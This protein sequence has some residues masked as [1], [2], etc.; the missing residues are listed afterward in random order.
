MIRRP[1]RSTLSSS[2]AASDVYKRQYQRRVR[3]QDTQMPLA[4]P[5][6]EHWGE[7]PARQTMDLRPLPGGY[8]TGSGTLAGWIQDRLDDDLLAALPYAL[9]AGWGYEQEA[10]NE[11]PAGPRSPWAA[12]QNTAGPPTPLDWRPFTPTD[13]PCCVV[14]GRPFF[15]CEDDAEALRFESCIPPYE[16]AN[17]AH[18]EWTNP[19]GDGVFNVTLTNV[20]DAPVEVKPLLVSMSTGEVLWDDCLVVHLGREAFA[21]P[22]AFGVHASRVRPLVLQSGETVRHA[23]N[24]LEL[25]DARIYWPRGG[26]RLGAVRFSLGELVAAECTRGVYYKSKHHDGK[27]EEA[28]TLQATAI[29]NRAD[30]LQNVVDTKLCVLKMGALCAAGRAQAVPGDNV[31]WWVLKIHKLLTV[32]EQL[33]E[34]LLSCIEA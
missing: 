4:K 32:E 19:D 5:L 14:T 30:R 11:A 6:P 1:P 18:P 16:P 24:I 3:G 10:T 20:S 23:V 15:L 27:R 29:Q 28:L 8:G 13:Q 34:A 2:S 26:S 31:A 7:P 21:H 12:V 25:Q 22:R 33:V 9:P 17:E